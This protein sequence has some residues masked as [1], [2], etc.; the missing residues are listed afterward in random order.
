MINIIA[1]GERSHDSSAELPFLYICNAMKYCTIPI[2]RILSQIKLF[3]NF[4]F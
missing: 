3:L 4:F 2:S 1:G